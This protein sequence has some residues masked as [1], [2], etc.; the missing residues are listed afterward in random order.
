M[1]KLICENL[2]VPRPHTNLLWILRCPIALSPVPPQTPTPPQRQLT[3]L[4]APQSLLDQPSPIPS[5]YAA[6]CSCVTELWPQ[7]C[8]LAKGPSASDLLN[9]LDRPALSSTVPT[10]CC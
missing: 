2:G 6:E 4:A 5:F 9:F 7:V 10:A 3:L 1:N 8:M